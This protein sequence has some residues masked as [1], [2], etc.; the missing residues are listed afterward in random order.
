MKYNINII[1]IFYKIYINPNFLFI[2]N[3]HRKIFAKPD[4]GKLT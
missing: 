3:S 1:S 2:I 4:F